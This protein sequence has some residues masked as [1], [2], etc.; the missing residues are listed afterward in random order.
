MATDEGFKIYLPAGALPERPVFFIPGWGFDGRVLELAPDL[1]WLAPLGLIAPTRFADQLHDWLVAQRIAAIDLVG[2]SLGGYCALDFARRYPEQ[3]AS[4]TLLGVRAQWPAAEIETLAAELTAG[5]QAL[6]ASFYRKCFLGYKAAYQ[7]FVAELEPYY[8][9]LAEPAVLR[10][11]LHY[12]ADFTM[13]ERASCETLCCHGRR[14]VIAPLGERITLAGAQQLTFEHGGHPLFLEEGAVR[15]GSQR[16]R[17]IRQRFSKA[18][19]TYD[20]H[21][22]V[23]AELAATLVAGLDAGAAV[24]TILE[25]GCGTGNYTVRLAGTFPAARLVCLDFSPAMLAQARRKV[26][27]NGRIAFL[28][29]DAEPFLAAGHGRFDLIT[30]NATMQWFEELECAFAGIAVMLTP[31]GFFWGSIFG[32]ETLHELEAGLRQVFEGA[33]HASASR[34]P[35]G[36]E[37]ATM[38]NR[39]FG[40]VELRELRLTRQY[41]TLTELLYHFKKTG[42]GGWHAGAPFW[43]RQRLAALEQWFLKEHGGFRLTFQIFLVRC[44]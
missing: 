44:R 39:V 42:T 23:Q 21:A 11:G 33:V 38:A 18:A 15:P 37:L 13:P 22:D 43:G 28:G 14:D 32:H 36:E 25:L 20:H 31:T 3:V 4:L 34:F 17:A 40:Q 35:T 30:A 9:G 6:L 26:G 10:E 27:A 19:A 5:P 2:W 1:S 29:A 12:L 7:R 8:L 41:A 16:K 24:E